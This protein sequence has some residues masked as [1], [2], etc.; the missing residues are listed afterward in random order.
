M[1]SIYTL[2]FI[3]LPFLT[4]SQTGTVQEI[5]ELNTVGEAD[6]YPCVLP[7]GLTLYFTQNDS[8]SN[9][10]YVS[11]RSSL[12]GL[13]GPGELVD[14]PLFVGLTSAWVTNNELKVFFCVGSSI[15]V[16]ERST[17]LDPFQA[18]TEITLTGLTSYNFVFG[19]SL[20][21][22]EEDLFLSYGAV[23]QDYKIGMFSLV[24]STTYDFVADFTPTGLVS[25]AGQIVRDDVHFLCG[26]YDSVLDSTF[27]YALSR[28]AVGDIFGSPEKLD[29]A[30][31]SGE[32][33][34]SHP[35]YADQADLLIWTR[36]DVNTWES[37][38]LFQVQ[39]G[40]LGSNELSLV[41]GNVSMYP[42][43][44]VDMVSIVTE[45]VAIENVAVH[46]YLGQ[47]I[48]VSSYQLSDQEVSLLLGDLPSGNYTVAISS[49]SGSTTLPLVKL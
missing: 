36:S 38:D 1:K 41:N 10:F 27:I 44:G 34:Q 23:N 29:I 3:V 28:N 22:N 43:P 4:F 5:T 12:T 2:I 33:F 17:I 7:D 24:N 25:E 26:F 13:W 18:P 30:I 15:F 31:N 45:E 21:Q 8:Q 47:K 35:S 39:Y 19:P 14:A 9:N 42:N 32:R 49:E 6:A 37:N 48:D 16:T 20:S 11:R 46:N 40:F